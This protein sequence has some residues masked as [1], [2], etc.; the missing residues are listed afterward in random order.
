MHNL[1]FNIETQRFVTVLYLCCL[2]RG[3]D[4]T[5]T[6]QVYKNLMERATHTLS[7]YKFGTKTPLG[8][9]SADVDAF[10]LVLSTCDMTETKKNTIRD[11][12]LSYDG[13]GSGCGIPVRAI[14][15]KKSTDGMFGCHG[16]M[17]QHLPAILQGKEIQVMDAPLKIGLHE[18]CKQM[19]IDNLGEKGRYHLPASSHTGV[20]I[21]TNNAAIK[22][23]FKDLAN[24]TIDSC[25][26]KHLPSKPIYMIHV[27]QLGCRSVLPDKKINRLFKH[28]K[29]MRDENIMVE[30]FQFDIAFCIR[31]PKNYLIQSSTTKLGKVNTADVSTPS[32][33]GNSLTK[34]YPL[35]VI[36]D[37]HGVGKIKEGTILVKKDK[38]KECT[39]V[40]K[41]YSED[42]EVAKSFLD[43][44]DKS[45]LTIHDGD[46]FSIKQYSTIAHWVMQNRAKLPLHFEDMRD[47]SH[48]SMESLQALTKNLR[49]I[50]ENGMKMVKS[51]G[52]GIRLEVSIRPAENKDLSRNGHFNDILLM[53]C[54]ALPE[55]LKQWKPTVKFLPTESTE[56][57]ALAMLSNLSS[58]LA[59][60][61]QKSFREIWKKTAAI[62]WLQFYL[63]KVMITMGIIPV[64]ELRFVRPWIK[65]GGV[66]DP[67][68]DCPGKDSHIVNTKLNDQKERMARSLRGYLR[69]LEFSK[70]GQ[71]CIYKFTM[72]TDE[73]D[74][75]KLFTNLGLQDKILLA[76]H[77]EKDILP[78]ISQF[79]SGNDENS[80]RQEGNKSHL[81]RES[82]SL[83]SDSEM[84]ND[85]DSTHW[86]D[87]KEP[88]NLHSLDKDTDKAPHPKHPMASVI[89][90]FSLI[91]TIWNP[92]KPGFTLTL[93]MYVHQLIMNR[94]TRSAPA[95]NNASFITRLISKCKNCNT[96]ITNEDLRELC[97]S[98]QLYVGRGRMSASHFLQALS[99]EYLF[100]SS[101]LSLEHF[102]E[103][104]LNE[105]GQNR[106]LNDVIGTDLA[107]PIPG[108]LTQA[109]LT[110]Y[111]R[112]S[113]NK[114]IDIANSDSIYTHTTQDQLTFSVKESSI[115]P[116][117]VVA[118]CFNSTISHDDFDGALRKKLKTY[119]NLARI[120]LTEKAT[121]NQHFDSCKKLKDLSTRYH[122]PSSNSCSRMWNQYPPKV[123]FALISRARGVNIT[124]YDRKNEKTYIYVISGSRSIKYQLSGIAI[125]PKKQ[126]YIFSRTSE[127]CFEWNDVSNTTGNRYNSIS[128]FQLERIHSELRRLPFTN[129]ANQFP[130]ISNSRTTQSFEKGVSQLLQ[131]LDPLYIIMKQ[132]GGINKH[133]GGNEQPHDKLGLIPFLEELSSSPTHHHGLHLFDQN[134]LSN[135]PALSCPLSM[136]IC[137][138]REQIQSEDHR[139]ICPIICLKHFNLMLAV[140]EN[141]QKTKRTYLYTFDSGKQ[142]VISTQFK[143]YFTFPDRPAAVFIYTNGKSSRPDLFE[144]TKR[145]KRTHRWGYNHS[146]LGPFSHI[147]PSC[148]KGRFLPILK[149][150]LKTESIIDGENFGPLHYR[151]PIGQSYL[152]LNII[153]HNGWQVRYLSEL[154][155][156]HSVLILIFPISRCNDAD[157]W[158]ICIVHHPRQDEMDALKKVKELTSIAPDRCD[159][160]K[161]KTV[162]GKCI[163]RC[164]SG[165]FML[166]YAYLGAIST[167]FEQFSKAVSNVHHERDLSINVRH[168]VSSLIA[169]SNTVRPF[170][171]TQAV[172]DNNSETSD[173]V[174]SDDASQSSESTPDKLTRKRDANVHREHNKMKRPGQSV[175]NKR[176]KMVEL[177]ARRSQLENLIEP[178]DANYL[179]PV[180]PH[181]GLPNPD[182]LCYMITIVQLLFGMKFSRLMFSSGLSWHCYD[183]NTTESFHEFGRKGGFIAIALRTLFQKMYFRNYSHTVVPF[184]DALVSYQPFMDFDN[185]CQHDAN[186]L[187]TRLLDTLKDV[188]PEADGSSTILECFSSRICSFKRCLRCQMEFA[189][190][191]CDGKSTSLSI[192]LH[193]N[194]IND[195]LSKYFEEEELSDPVEC[196]NCR[197]RTQSKKRLLIETRMIL[198]ISLKRFDNEG[199]KNNTNI[200]FPLED[201]D[202]SSF[203]V[204]NSHT[205]KY[206]LVATINHHGET[207]QRGHYDLNMKTGAHLWTRFNDESVENI[208][209]D[210]LNNQNVYTLVYCRKDKWSDLIL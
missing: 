106:I 142:R 210:E 206:N 117:R 205:T 180:K 185:K 181:I 1:N 158:V 56:R 62:S 93:L 177:T 59:F 193:G 201:L 149:T 118:K 19:V 161:Y 99:Q 128:S 61:K 84:N 47:I 73:R 141:I 130:R 94:L 43:R 208:D 154:D 112:T 196:S 18:S 13:F 2:F 184:K 105:E 9:I 119:D 3:E 40:T 202:M 23:N 159:R 199:I 54:M 155:I 151:P 144:Y 156:K 179:W 52:I 31:A 102:K 55:Y 175:L 36:P 122:I 32:M 160:Y 198:I 195:C 190:P 69:E 110:R 166:L 140:L 21:N 207:V 167:T 114:Y 116:Y 204:S 125:I 27:A 10:S 171:L 66:F 86:W 72:Q 35:H 107:I 123:V 174:S 15:A 134:T 165:F 92:K 91:G 172:M 150:H 194:N 146:L 135:C 22:P 83:V 129:L 176:Q 76:Y 97:S 14:G 50:V 90:S 191:G 17:C 145:D 28:I 30:I 153:V 148:L 189:G 197:S 80:P 74:T 75:T 53:A 103:K 124:F 120:F 136:L 8:D 39:E 26:V 183:P 133:A 68:H 89:V 98:L 5:A 85:P 29:K 24:A 111:F 209:L 77:L 163:N 20:C 64:F 121:V 178:K 34:V 164:E 6:E 87:F 115:D 132:D 78:H 65:D 45:Y 63:S 57:K 192:P 143:G 168:W 187:L 200:S 60:R 182:N 104:V 82:N 109:P 67:F 38:W 51:Y 127:D 42:N 48:R 7:S 95:E 162:K 25:Q 131:H 44:I 100:P 71:E 137:K 37:S 12:L 147:G 16:S 139:L 138:L 41:I 79:L 88:F 188:F 170:W 49:N 58:L 96:P 113:E 46:V 169:R 4:S 11:F 101:S 108:I 33:L 186:E 173:V 152:S 126:N 157:E 203:L 81:Y 70:V